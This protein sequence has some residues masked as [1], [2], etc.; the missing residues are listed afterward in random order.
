MNGAGP[1]YLLDPKGG[2]QLPR[3]AGAPDGDL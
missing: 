2:S 1:I 3:R